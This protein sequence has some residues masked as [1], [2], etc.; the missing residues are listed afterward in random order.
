MTGVDASKL[1]RLDDGDSSGITAKVQCR[2][3]T[4]LFFDKE[5]EKNETEEE[6]KVVHFKGKRG[7]W[8]FCWLSLQGPSQPTCQSMKLCSK[9]IGSWVLVKYMLAT[10]KREVHSLHTNAPSNISAGRV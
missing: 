10:Q 5:G 7:R 3:E 9:I 2:A 4:T 1:L 6:S 8:L